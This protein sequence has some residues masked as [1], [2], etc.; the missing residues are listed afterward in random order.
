MGELKIKCSNCQSIIGTG[1]SM[2]KESF[3]S[4]T[5]T[6]NQVVC[7]NCGAVVTWN[8]EDVISFV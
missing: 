3:E 8:K 2:G 5:L 1:I 7:P 6:N 4:S